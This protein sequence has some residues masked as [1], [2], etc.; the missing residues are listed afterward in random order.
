MIYKIAT[1]RVEDEK[2]PAV[3]DA[4][5]RLE[6]SICSNE[7]DTLRYESFQQSDDPGRFVHVMIFKN[8]K[9]E[10]KHRTSEHVRSFTDFLYPACINK[11]V[12]SDMLRVGER[13]F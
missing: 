11:P 7:P 2:I 1:Y 10:D 8:Q 12:F 13:A 9:S 6:E 3:L 4:I 5:E